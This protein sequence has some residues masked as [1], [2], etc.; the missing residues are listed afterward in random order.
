MW[1]YLKTLGQLDIIDELSK[2]KPVLLFKHSTRC[3]ISAMSLSRFERDMEKSPSFEPYFLD[4][5]SHRDVS[6]EIATRYGIEHQSPQVLLIENGK[7]TYNTSH[8][9]IYFREA[10]EVARH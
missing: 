7:C 6:N 1:N 2:T 8:N 5:I 4:L 9:G 3:G 10:N